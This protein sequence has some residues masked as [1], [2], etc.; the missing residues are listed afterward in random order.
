MQKHKDKQTTTAPVTVTG[1]VTVAERQRLAK[2][3]RQTPV[4]AISSQIQNRLIQILEQDSNLEPRP[5]SSIQGYLASPTDGSAAYKE[6]EHDLIDPRVL[7]HSLPL[8]GR[9]KLG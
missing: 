1:T 9:E 4:G 2:Y 6:P 7:R 5:V 3:L 8:S